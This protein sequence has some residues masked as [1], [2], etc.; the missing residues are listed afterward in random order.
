[1]LGGKEQFVADN[2]YGLQVCAEGEKTTLAILHYKLARCAL[3][4]PLQERPETRGSVAFAG[5]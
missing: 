5:I 1:M 3:A 2:L 4:N